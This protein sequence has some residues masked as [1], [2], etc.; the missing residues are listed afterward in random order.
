ML[1]RMIQ[2]DTLQKSPGR[3]HCSQ[4]N[5]KTFATLGRAAW[6]CCWSN[7]SIVQ[8]WK[9]KLGCKSRRILES[10]RC[11]F[12]F[13]PEI[14]GTPCVASVLCATWAS[15]TQHPRCLASF[16]SQW[17]ELKW[18]H[19]TPGSCYC[20]WWKMQRLCWHNDVAQHWKWLRNSLARPKKYLECFFFAGWWF[21]RFFLFTPTWGNDPIWLIFFKWIET[22]T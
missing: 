4:L 15:F 17:Q 22:T 2:F 7:C 12:G 9:L 21:Q 14:Q 6:S 20:A 3:I 13:L 19:D 10:I 18:Q 16:A 5:Q 8:F 1:N 11:M